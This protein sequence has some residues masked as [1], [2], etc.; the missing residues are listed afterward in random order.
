MYIDTN[1]FEIGDYV[2]DTISHFEGTIVGITQ[3]TTGCARASIQPRVQKSN[4]ENPKMPEAFSVDVL[5]LEMLITGSRHDH[6][7]DPKRVGASKGGPPTRAGSA[8]AEP[9]R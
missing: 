9:G 1:G 5:T 7:P 3:W 8:H 2:R 6:A 4:T